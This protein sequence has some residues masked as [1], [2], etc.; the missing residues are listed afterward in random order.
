VEE[1]DP[2]D[3][4]DIEPTDPTKPEVRELATTGDLV[5]R[6]DGEPL[7]LELGNDGKV[8][9]SRDRTRQLLKARMSK[10]ELL[11]TG[12]GWAVLRTTG[13]TPEPSLRER[14]EAEREV[15]MAGTL[16][17]GAIALLDIISFLAQ[18][19]QTGEL[20]ITTDD[21]V[22]S[23]YMLRG[24]V[25][26]TSSTAPSDSI[27]ELLVARGRITKADLAALSAVDPARI[28]RLVIER[29]LIAAHELWN[30]VQQQL[31]EIFERTISAERGIWAFAR[32]SDESFAASQVI[33]PTQGLLLDA[34][35]R[36]D[37]MR[38]Y[39]EVVR[40]ATTVV[41]KISPAPD[42]RSQIAKLPDNERESLQTVYRTISGP[43]TIIALMHASGRAEFEVTRAAFKLHA[44]KLIDVKDEPTASGVTMR[45]GRPL[46]HPEAQNIAKIYSMAV[47]EIF[48]E[49]ARTDQTQPLHDA[50]RA[51]LQYPPEK[52]ASVLS[53]L[54]IMEDG[55]I[56]ER[57][58]V[59]AMTAQEIDAQSLL[60]AMNEL[61][62]FVLFEASETLGPRR[63]DD[64]ARRVKMIQSMI[65]APDAAR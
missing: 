32:A 49:L 42:V 47:R 18:G 63:R 57:G 20:T 13:A 25:V 16:G 58:L 11:P 41:V 52:H 60:A 39:R 53:G 22:R 50:S 30:L 6:G 54:R 45:S 26:W 38:L 5:L 9:A 40:S 36:L 23:I 62:F 1:H 27:G 64:L 12:L 43:M 31:R 3:D 51:F 44:L 37:E 10:A 48:D 46:S 4:I 59:A 14:A 8:K 56:D 65:T 19:M 35:R 33:L 24:D 15:V 34:M 61:L 55:S 21:V 17:E 7:L 28:G 2:A 29:G